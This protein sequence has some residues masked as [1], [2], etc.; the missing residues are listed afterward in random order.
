MARM[1]QVSKSKVKEQPH[2]PIPNLMPVLG[3]FQELPVKELVKADWNYKRNSKWMLERLI[4]NFQRNG[5]LE[6]IVVRKLAKKQFEVVNGNHRLDAFQKL[7][8][9]NVHC[10]V[11]EKA[12]LLEAKRIA[13]ELNETRFDTDP[14][15]L[16]DMITEMEKEFT[17]DNLVTTLPISEEDLAGLRMM[18]RFDWSDVEGHTGEKNEEG[19]KIDHFV[20]LQVKFEREQYDRWMLCCQKVQEE[21]G[22]LDEVQVLMRL[23]ELYLKSKK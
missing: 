10:F 5:Q 20:K 8:I 4:N 12:S 16:S 22:Y 11:L 18:Q 23:I 17:L 21:K 1:V 2:I 14:V 7:G 9:A 6:T 15:I 19:T 13:V 3:A